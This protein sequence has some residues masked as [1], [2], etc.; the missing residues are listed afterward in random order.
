MTTKLLKIIELSVKYVGDKISPSLVE[1]EFLNYLDLSENF[2]NCT[3]IPSFLGSMVNLTH[4]DLHDAQFFGH[5]PHQ[6]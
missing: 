5:I 1:L 6:L 3:S 4:L 2:F